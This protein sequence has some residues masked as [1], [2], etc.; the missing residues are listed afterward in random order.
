[1][2]AVLPS[3]RRN[4][5]ALPAHLPCT[6]VLL[7]IAKKNCHCCSRTLH[8]TGADVSEML[9]MIPTQFP[10]RVS[11]R[12]RYGCPQCASAMVQAPTPDH[13]LTGGLA[14]KA[15]VAHILVPKCVAGDYGQVVGGTAEFSDSASIYRS[16]GLR[17]AGGSGETASVGRAVVTLARRC[18]AMAVDPERVPP[19]TDRT[20]CTCAWPSALR[21]QPQRGYGDADPGLQQMHDCPPTCRGIHERFSV[22]LPYGAFE[23][24]CWALSP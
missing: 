9:N 3:P 20:R 18:S 4:H 22:P 6:A 8:E 5:H 16:A 7:G 15:L 12:P 24:N 21:A 1:M 2:A 14:T 23:G 13:S 17:I 10:V 11:R 19:S